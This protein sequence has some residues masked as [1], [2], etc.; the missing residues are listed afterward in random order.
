MAFSTFT[1][2]YHHLHCLILE[3]FHHPQ[4]EP[5]THGAISSHSAFSQP[6]CCNNAAWAFV[7]EVLVGAPAFSYIGYTPRNGTGC[8][9]WEFC[10]IF[11]ELPNFSTAAV[12]F[13]FLPATYEDS[14]FL[15]IFAKIYFPFF[16]FYSYP[17]GCE[18]VSQMIFKNILAEKIHGSSTLE[19]TP[20]LFSV[21]SVYKLIKIAGIHSTS[22]LC[23]ELCWALYV[24]FLTYSWYKH[25]I[26]PA[27]QIPM[28]KQPRR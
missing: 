2:F 26:S 11:E 3:H 16:L 8:V 1:L 6:R 25:L 12:P 15:H 28:H 24:H 4:K 17:S 23:L 20:L 19:S 21:L 27:A 13:T 10:L 7:V 9:I 5:R 22:A 14:Q 18:M